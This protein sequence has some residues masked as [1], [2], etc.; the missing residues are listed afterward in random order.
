[1][2]QKSWMT[3]LIISFFLGALGID[4][5]YL[6]YGNWW[7]KLITFGGLGIWALYDFVMIL[8]NKMPDGQGRAL[9]R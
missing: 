8:L 5:L 9:A 3:A 7:L 1:M 6:G 2:E 4:R